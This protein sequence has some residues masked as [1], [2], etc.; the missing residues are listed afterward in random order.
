[1]KGVSPITIGLVLLALPVLIWLWWTSGEEDV[2]V[3]AVSRTQVAAG[4]AAGAP[5]SAGSAPRELPPIETFSAMIDQ[6]LFAATR[7]PLGLDSMEDLPVTEDSELPAPPADNIGDR[8]R[9]IG[10]I[11]E[12]GRVTALLAGN[13]GSFVRVRRG[14]R[15]E[16]WT[17]GAIN[18]QRVLMVNGESATELALDPDARR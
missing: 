6:P 14:D 15:V 10:T 16:N 17:V 9:L 3:A 2:P 8:Y 5:D 4:N 1:M 13:N 18:R 11:L 7:R 12:E